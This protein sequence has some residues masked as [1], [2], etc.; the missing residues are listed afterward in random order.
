MEVIEAASG[1][2]GVRKAREEKPDVI[3]VDMMSSKSSAS[4]IV[5]K[6]SSTR[7]ETAR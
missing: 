2:E 5:R 6:S 7:S 4:R 1:A 3:L